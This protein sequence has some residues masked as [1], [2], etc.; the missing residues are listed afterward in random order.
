M[1]TT[2]KRFQTR[3]PHHVHEK[4]AQASELLGAT[5]NQFMIQSAL[6]KA[7]SV[8][9]NERV[10][11]L[12]LEDADVFFKA[13]ENPPKPNKQLIEAAKKYKLEFPDD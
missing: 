11:K 5:L 9:E 12:T 7:Q 13:I 8:I 2:E 6:E 3:M 10:L 4:L 1:T